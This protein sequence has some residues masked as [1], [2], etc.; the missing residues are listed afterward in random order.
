MMG[1]RQDQ[2]GGAM[3]NF[4]Q[5]PPTGYPTH[6]GAFMGQ[7]PNMPPAN[8]RK[9]IMTHSCSLEHSTAYSRINFIRY[10]RY[11]ANPRQP[12]DY[13]PNFDPTRPVG[14]VT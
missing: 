3:A 11:P 1:M 6:M 13:R 12:G 5:M 14:T 2:M 7:P 4:N 9:P 10:K 8:F